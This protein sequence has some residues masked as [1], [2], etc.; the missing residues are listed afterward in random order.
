MNLLF[1]FLERH[2]RTFFAIAFS[3]AALIVCMCVTG[4]AAPT[5]LIDSTN[6]I[7]L[8]VAS[9]TSLLS[10]VA[11]LTGNVVAAEVLSAISAWSNKVEAGLKN[12]EELIAQYK[13]SPS[14]TTLQKAEEV[15]QLVIS[16]IKTFD[17]IIGVPDVISEKLQAFA[18]LLLTQLEAWLSL[19]PAAKASTLAGTTFTVSVPLTAKAYKAAHNDILT[20]P[21]GHDETDVALIAARKL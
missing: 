8:L 16:D 20:S 17:Q 18:Q 3:S 1:L 21:T 2:R 9:A 11:G 5:W 4:C 19:L 10:F 12:V 6:L 13:D 7:P 15:A 14:D